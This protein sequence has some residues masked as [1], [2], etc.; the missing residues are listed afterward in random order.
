[1]RTF[2]LIKK[3]IESKHPNESKEFKCGLINFNLL[4]QLSEDEIQSIQKQAQDEYDQWIADNR[5]EE[6]N[7]IHKL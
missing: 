2:K 4:L 3:E 1:M 6:Y 5:L 7:E